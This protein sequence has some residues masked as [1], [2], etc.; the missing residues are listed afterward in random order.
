MGIRQSG[1]GSIRDKGQSL[2]FSI[3]VA[4]GLIQ[5]QAF[6]SCVWHPLGLDQEVAFFALCLY[7]LTSALMIYCPHDR[8]LDQVWRLAFSVTFGLTGWQFFAL[9]L[10]PGCVRYSTLEACALVLKLVAPL[11]FLRWFLN[12]LRVGKSGSRGD[13]KFARAVITRLRTEWAKTVK[14]PPAAGLSENLGSRAAG[15]FFLVFVQ[16][17]WCLGHPCG[18]FRATSETWSWLFGMS[19]L[20]FLLSSLFRVA[21]VHSKSIELLWRGIFLVYAGTIGS[22][23][24]KAPDIAFYLT[25]LSLPILI[26]R[27]CLASRSTKPQIRD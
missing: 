26:L 23:A 4:A 8:L 3:L 10:Q 15:T 18:G 21:S 20:F 24:V 12:P 9:Q 2:Q 17:W 25:I 22:A 1:M 11:L 13:S 27:I 14:A 16:Y 6:Y 5:S 19:L 7:F